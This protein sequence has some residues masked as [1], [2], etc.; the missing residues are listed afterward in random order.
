M[1]VDARSLFATRER[2]PHVDELVIKWPSEFLSETEIDEATYIVTLSHDEKLDNPALE[3]AV[4]SKARYI[5][6]LGSRKTHAER[7]KAL[8]DKGITDEVLS[9][10]H[11]PIGLNI[12]AVGP[13]EIAVS[14]IA[15]IVAV[16]RDS[17]R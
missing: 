8:K 15:E 14:I 7:I 12:G 13:E 5:G 4:N 10:I 3:V 16:R 2:F 9:R 11:A 6:A 1:V 17:L